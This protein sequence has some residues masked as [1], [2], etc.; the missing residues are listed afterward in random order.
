[1]W[2]YFLVHSSLWASPESSLLL[3]G[4]G[5][6]PPR[7]DCN[8]AGCR[9]HRCGNQL[10]SASAASA[11]PGLSLSLFVLLL[12]YS[13]PASDRVRRRRHENSRTEAPYDVPSGL[14]FFGHSAPCF[15]TRRRGCPV[16][17]GEAIN[18]RKCLH[19]QERGIWNNRET[20]NY[21]LAGRCSACF[22]GLT[23][24]HTCVRVKRYHEASLNLITL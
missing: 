15:A 7:G 10:N 3:G 4:G 2:D 6:S 22:C 23:A 19:G 9:D 12:G 18:A 11:L 20:K 13:I 8:R 16:D 14:F 17:R 5:F 21:C 1:M 24:R